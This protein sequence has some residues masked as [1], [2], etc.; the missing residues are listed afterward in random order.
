M[1]IS[2]QEQRANGLD[3]DGKPKQ[4]RI[5]NFDR[6]WKLITDDTQ[7]KY[8]EKLDGSTRIC[9]EKMVKG[10]QSM[11]IRRSTPGSGRERT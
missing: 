5:A 8:L 9:G 4:A 2:K 7:E 10:N 6:G 3:E 11:R 1:R